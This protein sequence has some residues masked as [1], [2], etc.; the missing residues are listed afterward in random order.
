M[1]VY[2]VVLRKGQPTLV[3]WSSKKEFQA[4]ESWCDPKFI[5]VGTIED[6]VGN[7]SYKFPKERGF[8]VYSDDEIAAHELFRGVYDAHHKK[9][10][11]CF[12]VCYC[13]IL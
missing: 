13:S 1:K 9:L 8:I 5:R 4:T 11:K 12:R 6:I 10:D 2:G 3:E 7:D